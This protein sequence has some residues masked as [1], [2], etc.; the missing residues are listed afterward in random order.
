[1]QTIAVI[2]QSETNKF[3]PFILEPTDACYCIKKRKQDIE[4]MLYFCAKN[5]KSCKVFNRIFHNL[6]D[7]KQRLKASANFYT[8]SG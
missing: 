7:K 3:C 6:G 1:M 5:Y 8:E 4:K 2:E